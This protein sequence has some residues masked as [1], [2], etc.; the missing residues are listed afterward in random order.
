MRHLKHKF[1]LGRKKEHREALMA[2]LAAALIRHDR[3][4]TTLAK[5]KALRPFVEKIITWAKEA[6]TATPERS[7]HLRRLAMAKVRDKDAIAILFNEKATM[8][9]DR[10]G[11]YTRIYKLGTRIGDAAEMAVIQLIPA[12]DEGYGKRRGKGAGKAAKATPAAVEAAEAAAA[13]EAEPEA[14]AVE[15]EPAATAVG[16]GPDSGAETAEPEKP[17]TEKA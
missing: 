6:S 2:N 13:V 12:D 10:P 14:A 5:A 9:A 4:R 7:L 16:E 1:Q 17:A 3:I 8:F 15:A 11:G